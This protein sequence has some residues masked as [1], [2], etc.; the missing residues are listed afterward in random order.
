MKELKENLH[1]YLQDPINPYINAELGQNYE[2][3][4]QGAAAL[5]YFLRA[6]ELTYDS[7]PELAY[8]GILKTWLQL[9]RTTRRKN[10]EKGQLEMAISYLPTRPEAYLFLSKWYS[11]KEEWKTSNLYADLGLQ[12]L[13]KKPLKYDVGYL[14]DWELTFQKAFVCWY[15]G[16]RKLSEKLWLELKE[17]PHVDEHHREIVINNCINFDLIEKR[18]ETVTY[19]DLLPYVKSQYK[20]LKKKFKGAINVTSNYSQCYQDL[21]V[22]TALD[23]K[24]DGNYIEIGAG[25]P[26]YGNNTALLKQWGY[27]GVSLDIHQPFLDKWA[28]ERPDD[29]CLNQD[30]TTADYVD[31]CDTYLKSR[32]ID[33]LQLDVDPAHNTYKV[34]QNIPFNTLE[35]GV[36]TYEHDYYCDDTKSYRNKSRKLL[37]DAGYILVAGNISPDKNSPYEDWWVHPRL[38]KNCN[39]DD[40]KRVLFA[41]NYMLEETENNNMY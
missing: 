33:Y 16:Q 29:W 4:G 22:L 13:N 31:I 26:Y 14:G 18:P 24:K 5:S 12:H 2:D 7:D 19:H 3:I 39:I 27:K 32:Y 30:A 10:Y 11:D 1:K 34:L 6:S 40:N 35:F 17:N 28:G 25:R 36:I 37:K 15:V 9:N 20:T 23:G 21:F 41:S 38:I 8:N